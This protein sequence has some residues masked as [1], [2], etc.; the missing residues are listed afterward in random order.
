MPYNNGGFALLT[1]YHAA[2]SGFLSKTPVDYNSVGTREIHLSALQAFT[3]QDRVK[4][5]Y[6][7]DGFAQFSSEVR[8]KVTSGRDPLSGEPKGLGL[9]TSPIADPIRTGPTASL[10]VWG[11]ED[12]SELKGSEKSLIFEPQDAYFRACDLESANGWLLEFLVLPNAY[13]AGVRSRDDRLMLSLVFPHFEASGAVIELDV[14]RLPGQPSFVA[15][16]ASRIHHSFASASGW[17]LNGPGQRNAETGQGHVL[18]AF[19]PRPD[20]MGKD[21][22]S[23]DR[24]GGNNDA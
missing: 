18:H 7:A 10:I 15:V 20:S 3:A 11:L 17:V 8:G 14:V 24:I 21:A 4:L 23:L 19:Y 1:P 22:T 2:R 16:F 5:S 12:F 9:M 6:H 13:W